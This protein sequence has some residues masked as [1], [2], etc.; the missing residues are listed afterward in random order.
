MSRYTKLVP[1]SLEH[2]LKP[3]VDG[4]EALEGIMTKY[5]LFH[6]SFLFYLK[7]EYTLLQCFTKINYSR[8]FWLALSI[9]PL[10]RVLLLTKM[11]HLR[12]DGVAEEKRSVEFRVNP[13]WL[14]STHGSI[15]EFDV[16]SFIRRARPV[17]FRIRLGPY[18]YITEADIERYVIN[19]T[20]ELKWNCLPETLS[21]LS[22]ADFYGFFRVQRKRNSDV[23]LRVP[24]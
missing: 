15:H 4:G 24:G 17:I 3:T 1:F 18:S 9:F 16:A 10:W 7:I 13:S 11:S 19:L 5:I 21:F 22:S 12:S 6:I 8:A 20:E 2:C 14:C 23:W